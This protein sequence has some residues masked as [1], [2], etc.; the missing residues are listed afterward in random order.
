M[1]R[2]TINR[3]SF[4]IGLALW[5]LGFTIGRTLNA[6]VGSWIAILGSWPISESFGRWVQA[7]K[8]KYFISIMTFVKLVAVTMF[9]NHYLSCRNLAFWLLFTNVLMLYYS[10]LKPLRSKLFSKVKI[11][12]KK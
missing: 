12:K 3:W 9:L 11:P 7:R 6:E 4:L 8:W 10:L 5:L 2:Q 1:D